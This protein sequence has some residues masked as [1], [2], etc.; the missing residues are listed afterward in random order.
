MYPSWLKKCT[1]L[2]VIAAF[3]CSFMNIPAAQTDFSGNWSLNEGNSELGQYGTRFAT[4]KIVIEQKADAISLTKTATSITGEAVTTTE[5]LTSDGKE[6]EST[7]FGTSK[8]KSTLKWAEDG[9]TFTVTF[10]LTLDF[11][12]QTY[13]L[14]GVETWSIGADG[15]SISLQTALSTPQGDVNTKAVYDKQ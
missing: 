15:K 10:S 1:P 9:K 6:S 12:G 13:D 3:L 5:T 14:T 4:L 7:V 2:L 11:S 8:K